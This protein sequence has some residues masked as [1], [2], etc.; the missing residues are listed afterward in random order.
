MSE[1]LAFGLTFGITFGITF[2]VIFA[3]RDLV[4]RLR[5]RIT[6]MMET[7]ADQQRQIDD[8]K[9]ELEEMKEKSN[10]EP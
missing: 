9:R 2:G 4:K 5:T 6:A 3:L 10:K 7:D 8:L 1:A